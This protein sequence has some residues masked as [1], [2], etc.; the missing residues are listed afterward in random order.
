VL[1]STEGGGGAPRERKPPEAPV[2]DWDEFTK[3]SV[4]ETRTHGPTHEILTIGM[5]SLTHDS[6]GNLT[7]DERGQLLAWD[8]DNHL[9]SV[10]TDAD[11]NLDVTYDYDALGATAGKPAGEQDSPSP[12]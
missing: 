10:D 6:K 8:F 3:N 7:T 1:W 11:T 2:G 5:T 9:V 4:P 12:F